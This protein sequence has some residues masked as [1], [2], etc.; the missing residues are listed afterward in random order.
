MTTSPRSGSSASFGSESRASSVGSSR[1]KSVTG[2]SDA[3]IT[4]PRQGRLADLPRT[5]QAD[6]R[7]LPQQLANRGFMAGARN[8]T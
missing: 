6:D 7:K 8:H 2:S 4:R 5:D 3:S 1:S